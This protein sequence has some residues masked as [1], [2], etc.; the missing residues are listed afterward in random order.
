M[1]ENREMGSRGSNIEKKKLS[2]CDEE[3]LEVELK[4]MKVALKKF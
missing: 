2:K 4:V 3:V 1:L